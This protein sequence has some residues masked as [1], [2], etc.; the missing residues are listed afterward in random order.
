MPVYPEILNEDCT[1][2]SGWNDKDSGDAISEVSPAGQFR[3][4]TGATPNII[5]AAKRSKAM[6]GIPDKFTIE[7]KAYFDALGTTANSDRAVLVYHDTAWAFGVEF[8]SNGLFI[9]TSGGAVEAGTDLVKCNASA[10]WQTWRFQVD[11]S[12]GDANAVVEI[13]LDTVSQGTFNCDYETSFPAEEI[14]YFHGGATTANME[15]HIEYIKFGTGLGEFYGSSTSDF[16]QL[17]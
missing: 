5:D 1:D 13:F 11:K 2:I 15:S 3:F 17:L 7:I 14:Y 6:S 12:L 9:L 10:E 16:F 4:A 8:C